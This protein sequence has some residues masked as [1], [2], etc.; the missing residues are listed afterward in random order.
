MSWSQQEITLNRRG[1]GCHLVTSEIEQKLKDLRD[2]KIG[3][4]HLQIL[5]T[6]AGLSIN[7]NADPDVRRD[8]DVALDRIVPEDGDYLHTAEGPDDMTSHIKTSLVGSSL[9]VPIRN[10]RMVFG[11]WQ[12]IY[13]CEFRRHP[14]TRRVIATMQGEKSASKV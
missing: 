3:L 4:C 14:H 6:S 2:Y 9:T 11:T 13:L 12:G 10:G 7:E 5:H 1:K 8:M